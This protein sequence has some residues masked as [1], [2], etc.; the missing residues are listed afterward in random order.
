MT[1][2]LDSSGHW[3][4]A[5]A[6]DGNPR[7]SAEFIAPCY[8]INKYAPRLTFVYIVIFVFPVKICSLLL[9]RFIKQLDGGIVSIV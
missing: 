1:F 4:F 3:G 8:V 9:V 5:G 6:N 2:K 7:I